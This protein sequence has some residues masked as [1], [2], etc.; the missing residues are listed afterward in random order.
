MPFSS[1]FAAEYLAYV[2]LRMG[3]KGA[4]E[5]SLAAL[6]WVHSFIPGI[7]HWNNP[8]N[9]EFLSKMLS[10]AR[11]TLVITKNQKK[12]LNVNIDGCF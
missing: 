8:M 1:A 9:D 12:P 3:T 5:S 4:V 6:K 10:S 11:R 7:N 2:N